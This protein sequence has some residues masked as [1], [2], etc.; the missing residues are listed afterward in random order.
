MILW[1]CGTTSIAIVNMQDISFNEIK[2]F[3]PEHNGKQGV[4]IRGVLAD[5]GKRILINFILENVS[6]LAFYGDGTSEPDIY[7]L[8]DVLPK[9]R[10]L[11]YLQT[12]TWFASKYRTTKKWY[13]VEAALLLRL[14]DRNRKPSSPQSDSTET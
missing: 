1:F 11:L 8:G 2:Y 7:L 14:L 5:G 12:T 10:T 6:S 9:C 3:L 4:P 13:S